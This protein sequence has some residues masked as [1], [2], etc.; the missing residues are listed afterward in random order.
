MTM[1]EKHDWKPR[2]KGWTGHEC[3]TGKNIR[4]FEKKKPSISNMRGSHWTHTTSPPGW[5]SCR[6][7]WASLWTSYLSFQGIRNTIL[8]WANYLVAWPPSVQQLYSND[9]SVNAGGRKRSNHIVL[10][11]TTPLLW[12]WWRAADRNIC[13]NHH[14]RVGL[15]HSWCQQLDRPL[16]S[17]SSWKEITDWM[18]ETG[19]LIFPTGNSFGWAESCLF[20]FWAPTSAAVTAIKQN[21]CLFKG[22]GPSLGQYG[23]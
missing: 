17:S 14:T 22:C 1:A 20:F 8:P 21:P 12:P 9:A 2:S 4:F 16:P 13:C 10:I 19:S 5:H 23:A 18:F 11:N 3:A 7:V 15:C 6:A